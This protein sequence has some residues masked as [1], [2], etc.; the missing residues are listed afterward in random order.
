MNEYKR[1]KSM[2]VAVPP[3][4]AY[5]ISCIAVLSVFCMNSFF[6]FILVFSRISV[7]ITFFKKNKKIGCLLFET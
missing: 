3:T 6:M 7:F 4:N 2:I 1:Q 5:L